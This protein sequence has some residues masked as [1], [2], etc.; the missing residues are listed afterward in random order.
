MHS[1]RFYIDCCVLF[2]R[3]NSLDLLTVIFTY[4]NNGNILAKNK[5]NATASH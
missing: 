5:R 3:Y 4:D 1:S 2:F